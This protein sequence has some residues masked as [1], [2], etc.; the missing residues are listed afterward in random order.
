M[1]LHRFQNLD[2]LVAQTVGGVATGV[3]HRHHRQHLQQVALEHIAQHAAVVVVAAALADGDRLRGGDL[4]AIDVLMV[5]ERFEHRVGEAEDQDVLHRLFTEI[6]IDAINLIF[7]EEGM[8]TRVHGP[9]RLQIVAEWFLDN[10]PT[11]AAHFFL[12]T[13]FAEARGDLRIEVGRHRQVVEPL[14]AFGS[15][16]FLQEFGELL[17]AFGTRGVARNVEESFREASPGAGKPAFAHALHRI[18]SHRL[19]LA[20]EAFAREVAARDADDV[21]VVGQQARH[22]EME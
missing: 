1:N 7:A 15:L 14:T 10:Q 18:T 22:I 16:A 9:T 5:P 6:M 20:A 17:Q 3:L 2:L 12:I 21:R 13:R 11:E 8:H 19:D 4:H